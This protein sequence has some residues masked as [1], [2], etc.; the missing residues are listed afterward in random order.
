M[1]DVS[2][3]AAVR[4]LGLVSLARR[5]PLEQSSSC[6][7]R[8]GSIQAR[9]D[10][11]SAFCLGKYMKPA[12][13]SSS[14]VC[15][16]ASGSIGSNAALP[17]LG[18]ADPLFVPRVCTLREFS[19]SA[20]DEEAVWQ[21]EMCRLEAESSTST[22]SNTLASPLLG[23]LAATAE[24]TSQVSDFE[25]L[26]G[27]AAM[28]G[29]TAALGVEFF[30]GNGVFSGLDVIAFGQ[31]LAAC[32][33]ASGAAASLAVGWRSKQ[34]VSNLLSSGYLQTV[35]WVVDMVMEGLL[36]D[37]VKGLQPWQGSEKELARSEKELGRCSSEGNSVDL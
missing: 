4:E 34:H 2:S 29:L 8:S 22:A 13:R 7:I 33:A 6:S 1:A 5:R 19:D 36:F 30:T 26:S 21:Q 20:V 24:A 12:S 25:T 14:S 16:A 15:Q 31:L 32:L 18:N 17:S 27:R 11:V 3:L 37:E 9:T 28:I 23:L 35:D 10:P